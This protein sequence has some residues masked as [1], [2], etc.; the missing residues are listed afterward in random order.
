MTLDLSK[1][2][3]TSEPESSYIYKMTPAALRVIVQSIKHNR[4]SKRDKMLVAAYIM[5]APV[6]SFQRST[7]Y[8]Q[9]LKF[10]DLKLMSKE[11][12]IRV[13]FLRTI[14]S[15]LVNANILKLVSED[16]FTLNFSK[17]K[18]LLHPSYNIR[19]LAFNLFK[20]TCSFTRMD[21][22]SGKFISLYTL[23][24]IQVSPVLNNPSI[25]AMKFISI[26]NLRQLGI[27]RQMI[28]DAIG[29]LGL[30][31][32]QLKKAVDLNSCD[33]N[34]DLRNFYRYKEMEV[35]LPTLIIKKEWEAAFAQDILSAD[36]L[37]PECEVMNALN[38]VDATS[39]EISLY[40]NH[41]MDFSMLVSDIKLTATKLSE[42][43]WHTNAGK[44]RLRGRSIIADYFTRFLT[45]KAKIVLDRL[46]DLDWLQTNVSKQ[47]NQLYVSTILKTNKLSRSLSFG[48]AESLA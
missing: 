41:Y 19:S 38:G 48:F 43:A 11:L 18:Q 34:E 36:I 44:I 25:E 12:G 47:F 33:I 10:I 16:V 7:K 17:S 46:C 9:K 45:I 3:H 2:A 13:D 37:D 27:D 22:L 40:K 31:L 6:R 4:I 5:S 32:V 8:T 28:V 1:H 15:Q 23:S 39:H 20:S 14:S 30:K 35:H 42:D 24:V 26:K 21:V 29:P